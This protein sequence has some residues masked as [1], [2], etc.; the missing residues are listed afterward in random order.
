VVPIPSIGAVKPYFVKLPVLSEKLSQLAVIDT[1]ITGTAV[2]GIVAIPRCDIHT[3]LQ[4]VPST[5]RGNFCHDVTF[6]VFVWAP[7][8]RMFGVA[9]GPEAETVM[10]FGG[11]NQ[12]LQPPRLARGDNLFGIE[13]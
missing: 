7:G 11:Q 13:V 4:S 8:D 5:G 3:E 6:A 12:L 9:A 2:L 1:H 10:V